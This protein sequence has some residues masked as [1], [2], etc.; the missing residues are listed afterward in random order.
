MRWV[1]F[2]QRKELR[3]IFF[4]SKSSFVIGYH[5]DEFPRQPG[6]QSCSLFP[7]TVE[8]CIFSCEHRENQRCCIFW[9]IFY[10][11]KVFAPYEYK[12]VRSRTLSV[13]KIS[14][15]FDNDISLLPCASLCVGPTYSPVRMLDCNI[16]IYK[17]F[18]RC[19]F[20]NAIEGRCSW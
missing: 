4:E 2:V 13:G 20:A 18:L 9:C 1:E 16:D 14:Y 8:L 7:R 10:R 19:E 12:C 5:S 17:A 6:E 3:T 11:R 15:K